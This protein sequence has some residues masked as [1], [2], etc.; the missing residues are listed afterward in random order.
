MDTN[1]IVKFKAWKVADRIWLIQGS[2]HELMYVACGTEKAMLVDTGMGV[3]NLKAVVRELT[4]LPLV[5]VNTHGHPD[6]AGGNPAF[7]EV[8]LSPKDDAIM[9]E[10]CSDAY[11]LEDLRAANGP[12]NPA[13]PHLAQAMVRWKDYTLR[14]LTDGQRIDLG[15]RSFEV[16]EVPGHTPGCICLLDA[17]AKVLLVGDSIVATPAWL[18]LKHSLPLKIY[19]ESL[20]RLREREQEFDTVLPG[21]PPAPLGKEQLYDLIVCVEEILEKPGRGTL[22]KTFAGE[23]LLWMHGGAKIIYNPENLG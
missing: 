17:D 8:W 3:G 1:S 23:G 6:H 20:L 4:D 10:M 21:H 22:E 5:I 19:Y 18:Y 7:P 9:R 16:I 2:A 12:D 13:V 15:G 14:P 11:R